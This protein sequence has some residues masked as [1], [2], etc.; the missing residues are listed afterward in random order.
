[1]HP[2]IQH[3]QADIEALREF[4]DVS[5]LEVDLSKTQAELERAL[6]GR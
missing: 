5:H 6:Q 2:Q 4:G 3:Q 1:M